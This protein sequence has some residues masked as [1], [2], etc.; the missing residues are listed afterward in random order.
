[1]DS[2]FVLHMMDRAITMENVQVDVKE[3][4]KRLEIEKEELGTKR[5]LEKKFYFYEYYS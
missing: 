5:N 2:I 4:I 1:M 3:I